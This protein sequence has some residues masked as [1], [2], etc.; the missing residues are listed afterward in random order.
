MS[1][2]R[3]I[4]PRKRKVAVELVE[5][6]DSSARN[7][8][9]ENLIKAFT[10]AYPDMPEDD[11]RHSARNLAQ[12]ISGVID[13]GQRTAPDYEVTHMDVANAFIYWLVANTDLEGFFK[14]SNNGSDNGRKA[15][16]DSQPI[17]DQEEMEK[18]FDEVVARA[19][20]ML[21]GME[22][23]SENSGLYQDFVRG[24]AAIGAYQREKSRAK[25]G[26]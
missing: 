2:E 21:I 12:V 1:Q 25:I 24:S 13:I 17:H 3:W 7:E 11:A 5:E 26:H 16:A 14:G 20:D 19:A 9:R 15:A 8:L 23:L 4:A 18:L 22:V 10:E 6:S